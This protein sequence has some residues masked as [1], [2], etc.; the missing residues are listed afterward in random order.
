MILPIEIISEIFNNLST[1]LLCRYSVVSRSVN[2]EIKKIIVKRF[3]N[4]FLN[5]DR[6][7]LVYMSRYDLLELSQVYYAFDL[8]FKSLNTEN[9]ISTFSIYQ[10][11]S[12][13]HHSP[14]G[15]KL[16]GGNV[17]NSKP[18]NSYITYLGWG[19]TSEEKEARIYIFDSDNSHINDI[20]PCYYVTNGK[21]ITPI[22]GCKLSKGSWSASLLRKNKKKLPKA[23]FSGTNELKDNIGIS[24]VIGMLKFVSI[25][26]DALLVAYEEKKRDKSSTGVKYLI[27]SGG[28]Q[29]LKQ[30]KA[31][32][33]S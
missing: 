18:L 29:H 9:L 10:K 13:S 7:L 16:R 31:C 23:A 5:S 33:I 4:I 11:P 15:L 24:Y 20:S 26:A 30:K 19:A 14:L 25:K 2:Y 17:F 28:E 12:L 3:N 8:G 22:D 21:L 6:R 32:V 27:M 1:R